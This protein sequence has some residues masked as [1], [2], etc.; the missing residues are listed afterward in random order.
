[1]SDEWPARKSQ[2]EYGVSWADTDDDDELSVD[3]VRQE[4]AEWADADRRRRRLATAQRRQARVPA[5]AYAHPEDDLPD[6]VGPPGYERAS[7]GW[8]YTETGKPVPGARD[9]TLA[10]LYRFEINDDGLLLVP[11]SILDGSPELDWIRR[12]QDLSFGYAGSVAVPVED[13][14]ARAKV[15]LGI[16]APELCIDRLLGLEAA[17]GILTLSPQTVSTYVSRGRFAAPQRRIGGQPLWSRPI[18]EIWRETRPGRGY[19]TDLRAAKPTRRRPGRE[20][21]RR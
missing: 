2:P 3:R 21:T 14:A 12:Y 16:D 17:A 11:S 1:M 20:V 5:F 15:P 18:L 19:R 9:V 8:R 13:W 4:M 10:R 6:C 7:R